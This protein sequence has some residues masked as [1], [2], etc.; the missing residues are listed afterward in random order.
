MNVGWLVLEIVLTIIICLLLVQVLTWTIES[1][2]YGAY[3]LT[4][5]PK[6]YMKHNKK[7]K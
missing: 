1:R 6:K 5:S 7:Y 3:G 2:T 4:Q